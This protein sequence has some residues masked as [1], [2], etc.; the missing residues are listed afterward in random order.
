M[1]TN[2]IILLVLIF[3][4]DCSPAKQKGQDIVGLVVEEDKPINSERGSKSEPYEIETPITRLVN[5]KGNDSLILAHFN[6]IDIADLLIT[7]SYAHDGAI[8]DN[9]RRLQIY[10]GEVIK[11]GIDSLQYIVKGKTKVKSNICNFVGKV[12]LTHATK[13]EETGEESAEAEQ[14]APYEVMGSLGGTFEFLE[15]KD[16]RDAGSFSGSFTLLWNIDGYRI[17]FGDIWYTYRMSTL[18]FSG[19]WTP[20]GNGTS[21]KVCWSNY[22]AECLPSD[23]NCSDGP[24]I[25][26]CEEFGREGWA[27]LAAMFNAATEAQRNEARKIENEKWWE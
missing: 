19:I 3:L 24:D 4:L 6:K 20:Y 17:T 18:N 27:T 23:F 14:G 8:G 2:M 12:R 13:S 15:D 9:Y 11:S 7:D 22:L 26:P 16:Q 10:M 5:L 1:K 21:K 25:I